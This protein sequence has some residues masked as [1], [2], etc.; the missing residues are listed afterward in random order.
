V[1]YK[2]RADNQYTEMIFTT[3]KVHLSVASALNDPFECSLKEIGSEWIKNE[4][5]KMKQGS[6]SGFLM[7]ASQSI[8]NK[9]SSF[10]MSH[11]KL[12]KVLKKL[13]SKKTV[14][15]QY[16]YFRKLMLEKMGYETSNADRFFANINEQLERVGIFSLAESSSNQLMWSHY[17]GEHYGICIGFDDE[18]P[19]S[20]LNDPD[21]CLKVNYS[22]VLPEMSKDGFKT[23][24]GMGVNNN[25][26]LHNS[27]FQLSFTDSTLQ[28]VISTKPTS[29]SYEEERRYVEPTGG[30]HNWPSKITEIVF[31]LKCPQDRREYYIDLANRNVPHEVNLY[32]MVKANNS[33]KVIKAPYSTLKTTP[34]NVLDSREYVNDNGEKVQVLSPEQF[35]YAVED[36]IRQ[37]DYDEALFQVENALK[38]AVGPAPNLIALKAMA[39]GHK[40]EHEKALEQFIILDQLCPDDPVTLYQISCAL[41]ACDRVKEAIEIL[42]KANML[43]HED[44]SIPYNIGSNIIKLDGDINEALQ[45]LIT[46]RTLKHPKASKLIEAIQKQIA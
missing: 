24:L 29:W 22:D 16:K 15:E 11:K 18:E 12:T 31:G 34:L 36:L 27:G 28:R 6:I 8:K 10:G 39:L 17:G 38:E 14:D 41:S 7:S 30:A 45:Y 19:N 2:Y 21:Y 4:V 46:A 44:P 1:L 33:N 9:E 43:P 35:S 26:Q 40:G 32:E 25:G 13:G 5:S 42:K 3:G 20:K 23:E 37:E